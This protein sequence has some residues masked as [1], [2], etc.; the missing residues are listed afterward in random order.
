MMLLMFS[1]D[2]C[3]RATPRAFTPRPAQ[4]RR[5]R[6]RNLKGPHR[7]SSAITQEPDRADTES[8][9]ICAPRP[10]SRHCRL[11]AS[12]DA[13][14]PTSELRPREHRRAIAQ[15]DQYAPALRLET[16]Q[17]LAAMALAPPNTSKIRLARCSRSEHLSVADIAVDESHVIKWIELCQISITGK[18]SDLGFTGNSP[19]RSIN[20]LP[21]LS[22]GDQVGNGHRSACAA[23]RRRRSAARA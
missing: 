15:D 18:H 17:R 6:S 22:I 4:Y 16:F 23:H 1:L 12:P 14:S 13:V 8:F 20:L 19:T 2:C 11:R 10:T 3:Q 21:R 9:R 7:S 5:S